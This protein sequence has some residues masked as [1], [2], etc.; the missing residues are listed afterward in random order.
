[1]IST[2][3]AQQIHQILIDL[4]G[5]RQGVRDPGALE[6]AL[7]RPHQTF[8]NNELYPSV[9]E[10]AASLLESILTNYPFI[11]GNKRT[12]YVL[13][14]LYLLQQKYD[15]TASPDNKYEF[16]INI[17]TG[18]LKFDRIVSWLKSNTKSKKG[19]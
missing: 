11:D 8:D 2:Q 16:V 4:F 17:A 18:T 15:I 19:R 12:G 7:S 10:K 14:R 1:M 6:S 9:I 13:L 5:G 3:E